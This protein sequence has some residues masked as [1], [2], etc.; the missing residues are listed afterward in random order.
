[1]ESFFVFSLYMN[2]IGLT[3][4]WSEISLLSKE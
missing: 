2:S 1:V 3:G 4:H